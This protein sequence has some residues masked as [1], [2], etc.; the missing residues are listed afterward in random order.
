MVGKRLINN[1][2]PNRVGLRK[3]LGD[4]EADVMDVLWLRRQATVREVHGCLCEEREIAYTTVM[5]VM[6]RLTQKKLLVREKDGNAFIYAPVLSKK[7]FTKRAVSEIVDGLMD[8]FAEPVM[9]HLIERLGQ[10]D[11]AKL[12]ELARLVQARREQ[13]EM[14]E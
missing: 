5:T 2:N 13:E 7:E 4:L 10:E 12:E 6:A 1:L 11:M 8:G 3:I 14:A 9:A